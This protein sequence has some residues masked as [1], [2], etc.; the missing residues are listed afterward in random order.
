[1]FVVTSRTAPRADSADQTASVEKKP[2]ASAALDQS[3]ASDV[4]QNVQQHGD[5]PTTEGAR[6]INMDADVLA[7]ILESYGS[8]G[9]ASWTEGPTLQAGMHLGRHAGGLSRVMDQ[10]A[11]MLDDFQEDEQQPRAESRKRLKSYPDQAPAVTRERLMRDLMGG[12]AGSV[13]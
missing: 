10:G 4:E 1:M 9:S 8:E 2:S 6:P 11:E 3:L 13:L 12:P 5:T 7:M